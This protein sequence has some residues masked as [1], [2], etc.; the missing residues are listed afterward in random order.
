MDKT[1]LLKGELI[2]LNVKI[3]SKN[4]EGRIIDETKNML[5]IEHKGVKK[6]MIK[7]GNVFKFKETK[8]DGKML[9]GR[10]EE[11]IKKI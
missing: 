5:T 6:Q 4:I 1:K 8:I 2:G 9:V 7:N 10:P 11:R 3:L